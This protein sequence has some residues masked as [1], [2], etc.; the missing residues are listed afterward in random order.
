MVFRF[1]AVIQRV[2]AI[3]VDFNTYDEAA[4]LAGQLSRVKNSNFTLSVVLVDNGNAKVLSLSADLKSQGVQLLRIKKNEGYAAG[5]T[6]A[7]EAHPG[8]DAF[9][10]LNSDLEVEPDTLEKLVQVLNEHPKVAAVGPR[11]FKGRTSQVWGTCGTVDP[12]RGTTAMG[13]RAQPGVLAK[14]SYIP[15]CSLLVRAKAYDEVGGLPLEYRMYYE[16]TELCIRL[17]KRGWD[18]FVETTAM[19]YHSVKSME[20]GI[21]ARHFAYYFPRNSLYFWNKNFQIPWQRQFPRML[22]MV[23][24]ELI[25]PLRRASPK[26]FKDRLLYISTGIKDAL[27]FLKGKPTHDHELFPR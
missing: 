7:I 23:T 13:D 2:L 18:L 5:L 11:V 12:K 16:E 17:Q 20:K 1:R 3:I 26:D 15:G 8:Y 14:W 19:A 25:L 10:F 27:P 22:L 4:R 24:K 6:A 9:W 21:P